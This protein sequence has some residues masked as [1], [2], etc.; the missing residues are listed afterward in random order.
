MMTFAVKPKHV[1]LFVL[2]HVSFFCDAQFT[3]IMIDNIGDPEE[4]SIAINPI[5]TNQLVAGSNIDNVYY[6][7][8]GG[9]T[10]T[11]NTLTSTFGVW[12]DP[13]ILA[14]TMGNFYFF[15]LTYGPAPTGWIDRIACQKSTDAGVTWNNGSATGLNGSKDQD[16]EWAAFDHSPSSSFNGNVYVTWTEF[17]EYANPNPAFESR[18]RFA[19]STDLTSTWSIPQTI[20]QFSGDCI[21]EDN[22]AEGAVPC[23]GPNGEVYVAWSLND[24]IYFDR[25][26]DG[27]NTWLAT[28]IIAATQPGGWDYTIGGHDR[29]N[30][31]P[32]TLTDLSGGPYNGTIYINWSDQRNGATDTDVWIAKSTDG[33]NTWGL[34]VRVNNDAPGKQNYLSWMTIDQVTGIIYIIFYDRRSYTNNQ[35]DVYVAYSS[36]GGATFNNVKISNT[37]FTPSSSS[38]FG[39]YTNITAHNGHIRPIWARMDAGSSSVWTAI[40]DMPVGNGAENNFNLNTQLQNFPNPFSGKTTIRFNTVANQ[41]LSLHVFDLTGKK[42]ASL[43]ESTLFLNGAHTFEF[44]NNVYGLSNGLYVLQLTNR[45]YSENIKFQINTN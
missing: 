26:L 32:V 34:P 2:L 10:W 22:T 43:F 44:N 45:N 28:D 14:D 31:L 23:I 11:K 7:H 37:P 42:V 13:C 19:K 4:P 15:H 38:F 18:I 29:A 17:D 39:D 36:D 30:G 8:D 25:S 1:A 6:S 5:N 21:D 3:N 33:G 35:T 12:G 20:S 40:V 27:G 9:L 24:T 16:K 41:V